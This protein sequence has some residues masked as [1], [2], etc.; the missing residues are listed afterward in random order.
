MPDQLK[1]RLKSNGQTQEHQARAS[2]RKALNR[3]RRLQALKA[4]SVSLGVTVSELKLQ[5]FREGQEFIAAAK[6]MQ[7]RM[8]KTGLEQSHQRGRYW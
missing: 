2:A 1:I 4:E 3:E 8:E 5:K 7:R 6:E